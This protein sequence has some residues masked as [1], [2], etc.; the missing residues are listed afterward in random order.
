MGGKQGAATRAHA[1]ALQPR[2]RVANLLCAARRAVAAEVHTGSTLAAAQRSAVGRS[3]VHQQFIKAR[4]Q[5]AAASV[6]RCR[7][8]NGDALGSVSLA[9][10]L[11]AFALLLAA[12]LAFAR[13]RAC[14]R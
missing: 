5:R 2:Q 13:C 14:A 11:C 3:E 7:C 10:P 4:L 1:L 9:T 8:A 6:P 12:A